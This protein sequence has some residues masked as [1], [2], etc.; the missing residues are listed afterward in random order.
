MN[1]VL[2]FFIK[3][4]IR[5]LSF[6]TINNMDQIILHLARV[7]GVCSEHAGCLVQS[8]PLSDKASSTLPPFMTTKN[9]QMSSDVKN[10][11]S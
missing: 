2:G 11:S 3:F 4:S 9:R 8:L 1:T 5:F 6:R 7:G 10:H